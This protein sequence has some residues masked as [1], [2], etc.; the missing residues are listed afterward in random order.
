MASLIVLK[1][2]ATRTSFLF[3]L[4]SKTQHLQSFSLKR[5]A[6]PQK[7]ISQMSCPDLLKTIFPNFHAQEPSFSPILFPHLPPTKSH[8]NF[9]VLPSTSSHRVSS[10]P[11]CGGFMAQ[12]YPNGPASQVGGGGEVG[13]C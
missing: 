5:I 2:Q 13:S 9:Q 4:P 3:C 12:L 8:T 6:T 1:D 10:V 11:Y 7:I